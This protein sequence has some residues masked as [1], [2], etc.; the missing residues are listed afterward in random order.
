MKPVM[1]IYSGVAD[2]FDIGLYLLIHVVRID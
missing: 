1:V 2:L